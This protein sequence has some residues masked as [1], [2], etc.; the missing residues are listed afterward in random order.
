MAIGLSRL[1]PPISGINYLQRFG[2]HLPLECSSQNWRH[3]C[4]RNIS[5]RTNCILI[6]I[7]LVLQC[8]SLYILYYAIYF[9]YQLCKA[10]WSFSHKALYKFIIIII[11]IIGKQSKLLAL[12]RK[13][14]NLKKVILTPYLHLSWP[15]SCLC[16]TDCSSSWGQMPAPPCVSSAGRWGNSREAKLGR[17]TRLLARWSCG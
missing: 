12:C 8:I 13:D 14:L 9:M 7:L 16:W 17:G 5:V 15:S 6:D 4:S 10:L 2:M 11:I 1:P 3:T